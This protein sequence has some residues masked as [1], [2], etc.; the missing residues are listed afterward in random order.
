M[1]GRCSEE[2]YSGVGMNDGEDT[3]KT[4]HIL[5]GAGGPDKAAHS[6]RAQGYIKN[7]I[8]SSTG[9]LQVCIACCGTR[10]A[11]LRGTQKKLE[12]KMW[13]SVI[14]KLSDQDLGETPH[15]AIPVLSNLADITFTEFTSPR[16]LKKNLK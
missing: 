11:M 16:S 12:A 3:R 2:S 8:P 15:S 10:P 1:K 9:P 4:G 5:L 14:A 6:P 13:W 7:T